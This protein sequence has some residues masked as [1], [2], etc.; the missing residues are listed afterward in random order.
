MNSI[1][2]TYKIA[3]L[4]HSEKHFALI[5]ELLSKKSGHHTKSSGLGLR[6]DIKNYRS[7]F[8]PQR[9]SH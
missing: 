4:C 3:D 7:G 5:T 8:P 2:Q 1:L 6:K 9:Q